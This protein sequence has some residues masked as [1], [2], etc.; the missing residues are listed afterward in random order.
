MTEK[1]INEL[2]ARLAKKEAQIAEAKERKERLIEEVR[3]HFGFKVDPRDERFKEM[4]TQKEK[5]DKKRKKA[6]KKQARADKLLAAL[7]TGN[8]NSAGKE[9]KTKSDAETPADIA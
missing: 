1:W 3:R 7:S 5:E 6:A 9:M 4:L 2:K 8:A